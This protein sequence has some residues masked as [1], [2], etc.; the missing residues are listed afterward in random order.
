MD[1]LIGSDA[2]QQL[3]DVLGLPPVLLANLGNTVVLLVIV[4][5]G[6]SFAR[7][8]ISARVAEPASRYKL[9]RASNYV[10]GAVT[11]VALIAI[12]VGSTDITTYLGFVS[13]GLAIALKE[14]IT[15]LVG[16][17]FIGVRQPFKVGDRVQLGEVTGD[18]V[19]LR[20]FTFT[21]MEVGNWV[22]ADQS[23]G[24]IVHIPNSFVFTQTI[25]SYTGGFDYIWNEIATV[26]TFESDWRMAVALIEAAVN[27]EVDENINLEEAKG[28]FVRAA[29]SLQIS[30]RY[31]TPIVWLD[32]VDDGVRITARYLCAVRGRRVSADR[33]WRAILVAF[34]GCDSVDFA[35]PTRRQFINS[36]EGKIG[37]GG[38]PHG[39]V[40]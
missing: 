37:T 6:R 30:Y 15:D 25:A 28:Q 38:P 9:A 20:L 26:V 24:R 36:R 33:M 8:L 10:L 31:L 14:P 11:I 34:E 13:A 27:D 39:A 18:V 5:L 2:W 4:T 3:C 40:E 22:A 16:W 35:Y 21:V 23:T 32:V 17:V 1:W 19:D 7:R 29:E 12:W